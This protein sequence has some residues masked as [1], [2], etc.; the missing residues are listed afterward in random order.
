MMAL[1]SRR[2]VLYG[3]AGGIGVLAAASAFLAGL[4]VKERDNRFCVACHLHEAKFERLLGTPVTDLAGSHH[5][6]DHRL[7]CIACHGGADPVMRIR[8]WSIAG[9]DTL[10]FLAGTYSEP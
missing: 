5:A 1:P 2:R 9:F 8:V 3:V 6:R 7:G 10:R 4:A